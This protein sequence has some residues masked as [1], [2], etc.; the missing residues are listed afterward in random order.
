MTKITPCL[1]F[2]NEAEEAAKFYCSVFPDSGIDQIVHYGEW[3]KDGPGAEKAGKVM[4]VTFHLGDQGY[5]ALNGGPNFK[6]NEAISL[7]YYCQSQEDLDA[8]WSALSAHPEA[9]ICGWLKDKYGLSW[10]MIHPKFG[11]WMKDIA[12]RDAVMI[13][14]MQMKKPDLATLERAAASAKK[15]A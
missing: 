10:Q 8:V 12:T 5:M 11:E 9:E 15:A 6:F 7:Q 2:D 14:V 4:C 13:A 1:W 3:A